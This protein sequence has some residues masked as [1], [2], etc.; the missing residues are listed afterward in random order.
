MRCGTYHALDGPSRFSGLRLDADTVIE[1]S[2]ILKDVRTAAKE[3]FQGISVG[4]VLREECRCARK[5]IITTSDITDHGSGEVGQN[6]DSFES[7]L[8]Q[9][10]GFVPISW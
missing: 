7:G 2:L 8:V 10:A 6:M 5:G 1:R 9:D 4:V 3:D